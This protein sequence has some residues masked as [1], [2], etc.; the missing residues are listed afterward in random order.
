MDALPVMDRAY[1]RRCEL[2]NEE[3][4]KGVRMTLD[5]YG[6]TLTVVR[7]D[8]SFDAEFLPKQPGE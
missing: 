2:L 8:G 6:V 4:V 7:Q 3:G 1:E 5:P